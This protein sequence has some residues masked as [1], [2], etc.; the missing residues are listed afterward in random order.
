MLQSLELLVHQYQMPTYPM[1]ATSNSC[2]LFPVLICYPS[3]PAMEDNPCALDDKAS[4]TSVTPRIQEESTCGVR[5]KL[6]SLQQNSDLDS[7]IHWH[8]CTASTATYF[9]SHSSRTASWFPIIR[10]KFSRNTIESDPMY[11]KSSG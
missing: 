10:A 4:V 2:Q 6:F 3:D 5:V 9:P 7:I 11:F 1:L 8:N